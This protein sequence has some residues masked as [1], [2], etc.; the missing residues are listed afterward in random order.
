MTNS[1]FGYI[2]SARF[3]SYGD[4]KVG[5]TP[6]SFKAIAGATPCEYVDEYVDEPYIARH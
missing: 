4:V 6:V 1:N 5:H 2:S 3:P